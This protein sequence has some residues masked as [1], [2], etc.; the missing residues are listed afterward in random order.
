MD[1]ERMI[2]D[3][4]KEMLGILGYE[5][6]SA[7]NGHQATMKYEN[8]LKS[9]APY[10]VVIMYLTILGSHGGEFVIKKLLLLTPK[11]KAIVTNGYSTGQVLAYT[12]NCGFKERLIKPFNMNALEKTLNKLLTE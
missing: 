8:C 12:Q 1:D 9:G 2:L 10:D 6:D 7:L 4:A 11:I 5:I 3:I